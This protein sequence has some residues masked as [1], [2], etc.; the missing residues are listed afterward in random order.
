MK[1]KIIVRIAEGLGNQMFMYANAFSLSKKFDYDLYLDNSSGYFKK[2]DI[3][4]YQLNKFN[5]SAKLINYNF[6]FDNFFKNIKRKIL[7]KIDNFSIKKKFLIENKTFEKKTKYYP[8]NL[9]NFSNLIYIEGHYE[10]ER[11]F[12]DNRA[13]LLKEFSTKNKYVYDHNKYTN[14]IKN[15]LNR[16]ISICVRTNRFSE[17]INN[18][19]DEFSKFKS[20]NFTKLNIDY[21]YRAIKN[22]PKKINN[23]LFLLWSNDHTDLRTYFPSKNFIFIENINNKI[24]SDFNLLKLCKNFIVGPTSFHWWGAWLSNYRD[25]ICVRP[26]NINPSSNVNFWPNNWR[27]L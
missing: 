18:T 5:I 4:S 8:I 2:K 16:I 19:H 24:I 3:R 1:K 27:S 10:S 7:I 17:R 22:F 13:L 23:P 11:Y 14:L 25:K 9:N 21:I 6:K 20:D 26:K 15:N 12:A